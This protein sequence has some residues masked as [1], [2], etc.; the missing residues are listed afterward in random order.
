MHDSGCSLFSF[1]S[2]CVY[3]YGEVA[4]P[5]SVVC[6]LWGNMANC[7]KLSGENLS[8]YSNK[9]ELVGLIKYPYYHCLTKKQM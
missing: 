1:L 2:S 6:M 9:I 8:R 4:S 5:F 3:A 7:V